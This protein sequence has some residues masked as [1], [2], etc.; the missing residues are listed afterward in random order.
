M[1]S[2][3]PVT[4]ISTTACHPDKYQY[5]YV[6]DLTQPVKTMNR[7]LIIIVVAFL[8][9][10]S[11]I[12]QQNVERTK[13]VK[14]GLLGFGIAQ[15]II[16]GKT[17]TL[18][19]EV[20]FWDGSVGYSTRYD[21]NGSTTQGWDWAI[22]LQ[23]WVEPRIYYNLRRRSDRNKNVKANAAD[24]ISLATIYSSDISMGNQKANPAISLVPHWG[25]RRMVGNRFYLE[26]SIGYGISYG[27][28]PKLAE[29]WRNRFS[30][31]VKFGF[32]LKTSSLKPK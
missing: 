12:A 6:P 23:A 8:P 26:P 21:N 1:E 27:I 15:E 29:G 5:H 10:K 31:N 2:R 32:L 19:L 22:P 25:I 17:S 18:N 3:Y 28:S 14:V 30:L 13:S 9:F 4:M 20:G 24:F 7:I 16:L 11:T